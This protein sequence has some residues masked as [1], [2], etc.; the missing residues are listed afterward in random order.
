MQEILLGSPGSPQKTGRQKRL[1]QRTG[2]RLC[3]TRVPG[4][5][6]DAG[7]L[8]KAVFAELKQ[9]KIFSNWDQT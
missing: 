5:V 2:H 1:Y 4:L 8:Q 3:A 6:I 9:Q 7:P